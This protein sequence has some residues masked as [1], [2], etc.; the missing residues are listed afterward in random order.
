MALRSKMRFTKLFLSRRDHYE[1]FL[2]VLLIN[3]PSQRKRKSY[4]TVRDFSL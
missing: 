2:S 3:F 4:V 1:G